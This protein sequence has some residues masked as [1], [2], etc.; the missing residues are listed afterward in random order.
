MGHQHRVV[1]SRHGGPDV[2]EV[3]EED[4][5]MPATDQIRVRTLAA[6]VSAHDVMVRS[7]RFPGFPHVPF[8]PG[9]DVVGV[10]DA[11]GAGAVTFEPGERVG[12]LLADEGG[13]AEYV[14]VPAMDAVRVPDG[15]DA[16]AAACVVTN[17]LTAYAMLHRGAHVR[18]GEQAL[19]HGAAGGV[20]SALVDLGRLA[21]LELFGTASAHNHEQVS[22]L[23]ATPIDYRTEDFVERIRSLTGDGVDVVFD[24][25]GG[26]KQLWRS[27]S[28]LRSGGRM[29]WF[30]VTAISH[31]G[32]RVIPASLLARFLI[33]IFPDGRSA[34]MPPNAAEPKA[35]YRETLALLLGELAQGRIQPLMAE[36][37]SL[38][39]AERAHEL[40]ERGGY[41]GKVVLVSE[42]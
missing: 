21:G 19:V 23:G 10:V 7:R 35:W 18:P 30:G 6:G 38:L 37:I 14:I 25:I 8:T 31:D 28:A 39:E 27:R 3:V 20:G 26:W 1:V 22:K 42:A 5:P 34:P 17:Y 15:I 32:T 33:D 11:V 29:I 36:R 9:V 12:A 4:L 2:L 13:Y 41:A 16:A 40:L 24:P